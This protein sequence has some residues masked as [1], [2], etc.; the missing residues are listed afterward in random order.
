MILLLSGPAAA[1][2][3]TICKLLV[4]NHSFAPIKSSRF[5][6]SLV[7][8]P[9]REIT[10]EV[11]QEIGDRL[12]IETDFNWLVA[13]VAIPQVTKQKDQ[14]FWFVDS[15]RKTE[16]INRFSEAFPG[17]VLHCHITAPDDVLKPRL[18]SRSVVNGNISYEKTFSEHVSHPNEISARSL[19]RAAALI[20]DTSN[21][22]ALTA[23][24]AIM[25]KVREFC[26][27]K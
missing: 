12:D 16:Q 7:E 25:G 18:L 17:R 13:D 22:D 3:S 4:A 14:R 1:G 23:S 11:L 5:L 6:R 8:P 26:L 24:N 21:T 20:I 10:R 15:V 9:E 2:K 19:G 27:E